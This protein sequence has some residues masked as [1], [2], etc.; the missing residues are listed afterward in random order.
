MLKVLRKKG[1]SK[2]ILWGIAI[3]II[4]S[5]GFFG[6][7]NYMSNS[8][9]VSS[10]GKIHGKTVSIDD[11]DQAYKDTRM[12]AMMRYGDNFAKIS[13]FLN[14]DSE[15]W[16]RIILLDEADKRNLKV[17]DAEVVDAIKE[18]SFF[19]RNGQYDSLLYT[20]VLRYVLKVR[21]REFE[22]SIRESLK[23]KKLFQQETFLV[24]ATPEE[25]HDAFKQKNEKIKVSYVVFP[26][27]KFKDQVA[28]DESK[29]QSFFESHK[30]EFMMPNSINVDYLS[31]EIPAGAD[32]AAKTA[33]ADTT[34][35][36]YQDIQQSNF[37]KA[38]QKHNLAVNS[39]GFF[40]L[41]QPNLKLGWPY[42]VLLKVFSL[43]V[44]QVTEPIET[45][46]GFY[47]LRLKDKKDAYMPEFA[48][49]KDRIKDMLILDEAKQVAQQRAQQALQTVKEQL[50]AS[51]MEFSKLAKSLGF[52]VE[53][54]ALF[55]RGEYLPKIGISKSFQDAAFALNDQQKLSETV[56]IGKGYGFIYL[57][58]YEPVN[59]ADFE[60]EKDKLGESLLAERKG[61]AFND[62]LTQLRLKA[63]L[64]DNI[65]KLKKE[66]KIYP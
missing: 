57:E 39:S 29:S 60:K 9:T 34:K 40:S 62:F 33:L 25:V 27:E 44:K 50:S 26:A 8:S 41:E 20:D 18:F 59:E 64:V 36:V 58:Q 14:L 15:T 12:Q 66:Q 49:V 10:A 42:D 24:T 63:N 45:P 17:S 37:D 28:Y 43:N 11:F 38:A 31:W 32:E 2:K 47:I 21:P 35:T 6:T 16:D 5:F 51:P 46:K 30:D 56:E 23:L 1:V 48:E 22:E 55:A 65:S 4:I 19:Q 52:D 13:Q 54:T 3:V 61:A 7:A 53:Q